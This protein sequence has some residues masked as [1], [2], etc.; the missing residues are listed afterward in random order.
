M[1]LVVLT[2]APNVAGAPAV[3]VEDLALG[4]GRGAVPGDFVVVEYTG[5]LVDNGGAVFD[6]TLARGKPRAFVLGGRPFSS[7]CAGLMEGIVGMQPGGHRRIT[8]P[9]DAGF[10]EKGTVIELRGCTEAL[11]DKSQGGL[12]KVPPNAALLYEVKLLKVTVPPPGARL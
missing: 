4:R 8:V 5:R 2:P 7:I 11:C 10:G 3:S 6:D 12:V 1:G 9:A